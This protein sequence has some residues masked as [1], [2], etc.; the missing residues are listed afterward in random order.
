[1]DPITNYHIDRYVPSP[2]N[3]NC[4]TFDQEDLPNI[5]EANTKVVCI[6]DLTLDEWANKKYTFDPYKDMEESKLGVYYLH[7]ENHPLPDIIKPNHKDDNK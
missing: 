4:S 2:V 3:A 5:C 1:S 6:P 7:E